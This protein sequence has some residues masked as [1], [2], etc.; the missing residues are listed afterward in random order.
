MI[1]LRS[2]IIKVSIFVLIG[3]TLGVVEYNT[4]TA[5]HVGATHTYHAM[6]GGTD[7]VSG[8]HSGNPV[9]V[10]G[11]PVGK[12]TGV[13]LEDAT[14]ARVTFTA[15]HDQQ[16]TS[17]TWAVV[18]YADL[19]GQRYL[20]LTQSGDTPGSPLGSG[21]TIPASRTEPAL[22]LTALFNGFRP[23]FA[24]LTP[25]QVNQLSGELIDVLQGQGSA[26]GDLVQR[27]ADLTSNLAARSDTFSQVIDSLDKLL[28]TVS[29]HDNQL[30]TMVTS[31]HSLTSELHADGPGIL[32]SINGVD[33]LMGSVSGLLGSLENHNLPSDI[34]DLNSVSGVLARNSAT[35]DKLINGFVSAFGDFSRVMQNGSFGNVYLCNVHAKTFGQ[36]TVQGTGVVETTGSLLSGILQLQGGG[37]LLGG[38]GLA[39]PVLSAINAPVPLNIP[40]GH[41]GNSDA[42]TKV[43][44]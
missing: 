29:Q 36:A 39:T 13:T 42:H 25:Q 3:L 20:A 43:C 44:S 8:L 38:L 4:L 19:L 40:N 7:G 17:N 2:L 28:G 15:N 35:V 37:S 32:A 11:V 22:S 16:L 30:A 14:H 24:A 10:S 41:V 26:L 9:R 33:G 34:A 12:V 5:P 18:R 21:G 23:L 31:L 27:T 6:F 1:N